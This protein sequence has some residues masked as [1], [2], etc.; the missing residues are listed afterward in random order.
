MENLCLFYLKNDCINVLK[1]AHLLNLKSRY[2]YSLS[3][4]ERQK[5]AIIKACLSSCDVL[6]CDEITSALDVISANKII[7]FIFEM[8]SD[9]TIIFV[10]H[11]KSIFK[12]KINHF[13]YLE[14]GKIKSELISENNNILVNN[15]RKRKSK[16]NFSLFL[17]E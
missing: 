2:I 12:D 10:S 16:N 13:I 17:F 14:N 6:L 8:F 15:K 1:K 3:G 5:V 11:D 7:D 4:G 9:S